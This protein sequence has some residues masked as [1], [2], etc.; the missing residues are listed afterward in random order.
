M[1]RHDHSNS[2]HQGTSSMYIHLHC[3]GKKKTIHWSKG[4]LLTLQRCLIKSRIRTSLI[5]PHAISAH[6]PRPRWISG[7]RWERSTG[8]CSDRSR[9]ST[10]RIRRIRDARETHGAGGGCAGPLDLFFR[11]SRHSGSW[12][13][14][15]G[16]RIDRT[17][18]KSR[19]SFSRP[20]S[21]RRSV[22]NIFKD[23]RALSLSFSLARF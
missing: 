13:F 2:D 6:P 9:S 3:S 16:K 14:L 15:I 22:R 4:S 19:N 5:I 20:E 11:S 10:D 8:G 7:R 18:G 23:L 1:T 12:R 17:F 21:H